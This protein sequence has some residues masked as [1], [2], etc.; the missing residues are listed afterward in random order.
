MIEIF[1]IQIDD[2]PI[3]SFMFGMALF[4]VGGALFVQSAVKAGTLLDI[5]GHITVIMTGET[6]LNLI[7]FFQG[8][9]TALAL[10]FELS[11]ALDNRSRHQQQI[12]L[13]CMAWR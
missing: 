13:P 3:S 2:I 10:L 4:A 5:F 7:R 8:L 6:S 9:M 12:Q 1:R 11:M